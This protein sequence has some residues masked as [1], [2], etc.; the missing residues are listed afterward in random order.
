MIYIYVE[1]YGLVEA[2]VV[3][4]LVEVPQS[5]RYWCTDFDQEVDIYDDQGAVYAV[6]G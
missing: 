2:Q 5:A 1:G 6:R 4:S 3:A